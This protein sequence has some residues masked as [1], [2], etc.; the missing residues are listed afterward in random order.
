M[1]GVNTNV[2]PSV[3]ITSSNGNDSPYLA[4][5]VDSTARRFNNDEVPGD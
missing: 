1:C 4:P 2:V 5:V 3:E